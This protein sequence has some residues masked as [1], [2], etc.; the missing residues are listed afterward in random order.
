[1]TQINLEF[2]QLNMSAPE[3]RNRLMAIDLTK[4]VGRIMP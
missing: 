3:L 4:D 2:G 1:M